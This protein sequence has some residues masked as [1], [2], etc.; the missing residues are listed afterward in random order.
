MYGTAV[1]REGQ[2]AAVYLVYDSSE[3][4]FG[5]IGLAMKYKSLAKTLA[6]F[7]VVV[8]CHDE[9]AANSAKAMPA[10]SVYTDRIL[11]D[12]EGRDEMKILIAC[13]GFAGTDAGWYVKSRLG[14]SGYAARIVVLDEDLSKEGPRVP[15]VIV[16]DVEQ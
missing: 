3:D 16:G 4:P 13:S 1:I 10:G 7:R 9:E 2:G 6:P 12:L 14:L 8:L 11:Q 5:A 15:P